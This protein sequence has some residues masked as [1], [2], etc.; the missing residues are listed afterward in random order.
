MVSTEHARSTILVTARAVDSE[1]VSLA[2]AGGRIPSEDVFAPVPLPPVRIALVGGFLCT[3]D[4]ALPRPFPLDALTPSEESTA[5][6]PQVSPGDPVP[7]DAIAVVPTPRGEAA[8]G[9]E[10]VIAEPG[11]LAA[12]GDVVIPRGVPLAA[13]HVRLLA[14]LGVRR[15]AVHR[16]P[17][18][19]IVAVG[20]ELVRVDEPLSTGARYDGATPMIAA[21]VARC[22]GVPL[23][24]GPVP[25]R[26]EDIEFAVSKAFDEA[27]AL[28]VAAAS[29]AVCDD[30]LSRTLTKRGVETKFSGVSLSPGCATLFGTARGKPVLL[31]PSSTAEILVTCE[32]FLSPLIHTMAGLAVT[33]P[34]KVGALLERTLRSPAAGVY[35]VWAVQLVMD[36]KPFVAKPVSGWPGG[37]VYNAAA[38]H[39]LCASPDGR[40]IRAGYSVEVIPVGAHLS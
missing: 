4:A 34:R 10:D 11:S 15:V 37:V 14:E 12:S 1:R 6:L 35:T 3:S 19:A 20:D 17:R 18:I 32:L 36:G 2:D 9:G 30:D 28:V 7:D 29:G 5:G 16:K 22:G 31:L 25:R 38:V 21:H 39:G 13:V 40:D 27:D 8:L 26:Q 33:E 23:Q 24:L